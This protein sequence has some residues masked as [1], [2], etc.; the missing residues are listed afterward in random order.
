ML[1]LLSKAFSKCRLASSGISRIQLKDNQHSVTRPLAECLFYTQRPVRDIITEFADAFELELLH[2]HTV[3]FKYSIFLHIQITEQAVHSRFR[4][5]NQN[6]LAA[7]KSIFNEMEFTNILLFVRVSS[8]WVA[9]AH[10]H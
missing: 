3:K 5:F 1:V 2:Q 7:A 4:R 9:T 10:G 6:K 8:P